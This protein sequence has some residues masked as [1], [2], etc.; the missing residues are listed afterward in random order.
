VADKHPSSIP[1]RSKVASLSDAAALV[2]DGDH[3]A[4]GGFACARN[5]MA[6]SHELIR[7]GKRNLTLSGVVLGMDSDLLVG[8]GAVRRLIYG[9]G[10]LDRFGP[11]Q[12]VNRAYER[13]SI[14]AE[15]YSSLAVC[16]RYLAGALGVPFMPIK[17]LLGSDLLDRLQ[18]E[19][20]PDNVREM[21]CP[22][23]GEH[24]VLLRA[25]VPDVAVVHV[26]MAD[27]EGNARILG[28]R[29]DNDEAVSAA[30][31]VVVLAEE[32]VSTDVIRQ[33]PELTAIP[34]FRVTAVVHAPY[35][36]H[37]TSMFRC[38]DHD[39]DHLRL[40]VGKARS[41]AGVKE[42]IDEYV[43]GPRDHFG[44]L[45]RVGGI[46]KLAEIKADELLGY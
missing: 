35:G 22:F 33:Q 21:D 8:A 13:G 36:A 40:Y 38:Y 18:R 41:D 7:Q 14:V 9:G 11:I 30:R 3:I 42:Y 31:Q 34:A 12:C 4:V 25:L 19:T 29:W 44:Y 20:A 24:V 27:E 43:L 46:A 28:P 6:F 5:T 37:P 23:T 16:F 2:H 32:I 15:Y 1:V 10:S 26:Q 45:E 17:S 39:E